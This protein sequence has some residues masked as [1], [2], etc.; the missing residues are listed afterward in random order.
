[1]SFILCLQVGIPL[2]IYVAVGGSTHKGLF[3]VM[4]PF[5]GPGVSSGLGKGVRI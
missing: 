3:L 5:S 2:Q 4:E 1:M